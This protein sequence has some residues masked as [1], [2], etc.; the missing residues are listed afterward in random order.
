MAVAAFAGQQLRQ[1]LGAIVVMEARR[2]SA[3]Q[4]DLNEVQQVFGEVHDYLLSYSRVRHRSFESQAFIETSRL[5][6]GDFLQQTEFEQLAPAVVCQARLRFAQLLSLCGDN[7]SAITELRA[8]LA[9]AESSDDLWLEGAVCNTLGCALVEVR[10]LNEALPLFERSAGLVEQ[11]SGD[12][13]ASAIAL[14]NLSLT[15]AAVGEK[16]RALQASGLALRLLLKDG[17]PELL[18]P[19]VEILIDTQVMHCELLVGEAQYDQA[20]SAATRAQDW[21]ADSIRAAKE[22]DLADEVISL[23]TYQRGFDKLGRLIQQLRTRGPGNS[24][25]VIAPLAWQSLIHMPTEMVDRG[26]GSQG[27]MMGEFEQQT[28][29]ALC[30]GDYPWVNKIN[31]QIIRHVWK[32]L[33]VTIV[34]KDE[35]GYY[36]VQNALAGIQVPLSDIHFCFQ[37]TDSPWLRDMGPLVTR[38][39]SGHSLWFDAH[40][41]RDGMK[42]RIS[43]DELPVHMVRSW[44]TE[45]ASTPLSLEGGMILCNGNGLIL[46]ASDALARNLQLGLDR[47]SFESELSRVAGAREIVFL[48]PLIGEATGH[49]D[50]FVSFVDAHN[51]VLGQYCDDSSPLNA[52]LLDAHAQRLAS[53]RSHGQP[54]NVT[55]LPM[56]PALGTSF[57][58]YTNVVYA[59][60]VLL[61]PSWSPDLA[62]M[63]AEVKA[64]YRK[65]LPDWEVVFIDCQELTNRGGALHCLV[66][67]LGS[68]QLN[69]ASR[70]FASPPSG[71]P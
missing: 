24:Q 20:L 49:V 55:R 4:R 34:V 51:V 6:L 40:V 48:E 22:T 66:S 15:A 69:A 12:Q 21:L 64:T 32:R 41:I 25:D 26:L 61:V 10:R 42:Q 31:L 58:T 14:R 35:Y 23:R 62:D 68:A 54:L 8:A 3:Y 43:A 59:N 30:W 13:T 11:L 37:H 45:L 29:L 7:T 70:N 38:N 65:L 1:S 50:L 63:E 28:G 46:C 57:R 67:N 56:P 5:T 44:N 27:V 16:D 39:A 17:L 53:L 33:Q 19:T 36:D 2:D 9:M 47:A 18:T 60:G 71:T 52:K